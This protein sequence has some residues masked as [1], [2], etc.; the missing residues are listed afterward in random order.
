[1]SMP[2]EPTPSDAPVTAPKKGRWRR[3]IR[4]LVVIVAFTAIGMRVLMIFALPTVISRVAKFYDLDIQCK[5]QTLALFGGDMGLWDVKVILRGGGDPLLAADYIHGEIVP[6]R[7]LTGKLH[8]VRAEADGV[9]LTVQ[10]TSDGRIPL[11]ERIASHASKQ[12]TSANPEVASLNFTSP[13]VLEA[14]R[15]NKVQTHIKDDAVSPPLDTQFQTDIRVSHVTQDRSVPV[16]FEI[17]AWADKLLDS[18]RIEGTAKADGPSLDANAHIFVRG[19]HPG[20]L[21]GY[22]AAP[23]IEARRRVD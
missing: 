13:L 5:R 20:P 21:S 9:E 12:P 18:L 3:R 19:L 14:L 1:M 8:V 17:N 4:N 7:L 2:D 23:G 11:L 6:W 16:D 15:L 22:L 10:R